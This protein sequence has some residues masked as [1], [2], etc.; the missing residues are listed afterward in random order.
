MMQTQKEEDGERF[1]RRI[2]TK[3]LTQI[4]EIRDKG[5]QKMPIFVTYQHQY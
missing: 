5:Q 2:G 1:R 4:G 3:G